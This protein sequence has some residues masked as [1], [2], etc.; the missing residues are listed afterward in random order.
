VTQRTHEIGLR[1]ALGAHRGD[2]L[3][4]VLTQGM[5]VS[6]MGI[7]V[8]LIGILAFARVMTSLLY[9]V[10]P[11]DPFTIAAVCVI[12]LAVTVTASYLPARR[13]L[14]VDPMVALRYE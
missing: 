3:K 7:A 6:I 8:G 1:V 12:L 13:A 14:R 2:I 5:M 9:N 11:T 4:L 10:A